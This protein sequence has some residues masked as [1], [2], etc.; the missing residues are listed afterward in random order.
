MLTRDQLAEK[1]M[2][3]N[4]DALAKEANVAPK[5]IYRLRHRKH[6]PTL[7]LVQRLLSGIKKLEQRQAA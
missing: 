7:D 4:V 5:T 3:V 2:R 6:S 1:L